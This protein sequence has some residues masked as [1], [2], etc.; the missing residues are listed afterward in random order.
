M[1]TVTLRVRG[2][3]VGLHARRL[4]TLV[5]RHAARRLRALF[6]EILCVELITI[7]T[8]CPM[9]AAIIRPE[10]IWKIFW[11]SSRIPLKLV[12][13]SVA[14]FPDFVKL[15]RRASFR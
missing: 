5:N 9:A 1:R 7:G 6:F 4:A 8:A 10:G 12:I 2:E 11:T 13:C 15:R 3:L 14:T